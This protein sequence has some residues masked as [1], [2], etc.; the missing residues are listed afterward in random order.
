MA[1]SISTLDTILVFAQNAL[2]GLVFL[3][4]FILIIYFGIKAYFWYLRFK[5]R[6][7]SLKEKAFFKIQIT[8]DNEIEPVA[9]EQM[10]SSIY[11]IRKS[12]F[13][14]LLKEQDHVSFEIV[15]NN[16]SIEFY[17]VC[18]I[19]L[20][21]LVEKQINAVFP[22]AELTK[23]KPWNIWN[24]GGHVE[25][26]SLALKKENY[27]PINTYEEMKVDS[28]AVLTSAMS[29][30]HENEGLAL[31]ILVRPADD[32]WQKI[33]KEHIKSYFAK[34]NQNDKD[35]KSVG[36]KLSKIDEDYMQ[37]IQDKISK[38]GFETVI[39]IVSVAPDVASAKANLSNLERSFGQFNNPSFNSFGGTVDRYQKYFVQSFISRMF[40]IVEKINLPFEIP[41]ILKK[42]WFKGWSV[43]NTEEL[44]TLWHLPNENVKTPRIN[45][46]RSRGSAA[47]IE[48]PES[49]LYLG[50][51]VFRSDE[52]KIFM[53]DEDRRRHM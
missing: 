9:A 45:W 1:Q 24:Q 40:P 44:A 50:K 19:H 35:G 20:E 47:P 3:F 53:E 4:F 30:L 34:H 43:L 16:S 26:K 5:N 33:G 39:R 18:P 27:L 15:A 13:L 6:T 38:V 2:V 32:N 36:S 31:Q 22:S 29:K 49:G 25:F 41:K 7:R 11:G 52:V 37:K 14:N 12:G 23:V 21:N 48:L 46:L 42:E 8:E 28:I 10:Y 51:S 17:A